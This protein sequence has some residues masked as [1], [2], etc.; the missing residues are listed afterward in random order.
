MFLPFLLTGCVRYNANMDIKKDK[1]ME[2]SFIYA[3]DKSLIGTNDIL[4]EDN[5]KEVEKQGF[6]VTAY[7]KDNFKGYT[8]SKKINNI[9]EESTDKDVEY[10]LSGLLK[11]DSNEKK[12]LFKIN[13]GFL[14]NKYTARFDFSASDSNSGTND[15]EYHDDDID[16]NYADDND[17][18][19][20][21]ISSNIDLNGLSDTMKN[22]DLSY[23]VTLP[24]KA[25]SNNASN[26][27]EDGKKL[28]WNL[29]SDKKNTIEFEFELYNMNNVY[30]LIGGGILLL[31]IVCVIVFLVLKKKKN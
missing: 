18:D 28:T 15:V 30:I 5:I 1:S 26:V 21:D 24:Y 4:S 23:N 20:G 7:D 9:D 31:V 11:N 14:K 22:M 13:K 16:E 3:F 17:N 25:L 12:Y 10:S 2:F 8:I 19:T 6:S 27:L 29:A